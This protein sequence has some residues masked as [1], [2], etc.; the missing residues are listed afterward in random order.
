[1]ERDKYRNKKVVLKTIAQLIKSKPLYVVSA[2]RHS[3]V[4]IENPNN[5]IELAEKVAHSLV[6]NLQFHKNIGLVIASQEV[7]KLN[8][9]TDN[10]FSNL[11]G[12]G[13][14]DY[15]AE[16]IR[17]GMAIGRGASSGKEPITVIIGAIVGGIDAVFGFARAKKTALSE[18]EQYRQELIGELFEEQKTNWTPIYI[19]GGVLLVGGIVTFFALKK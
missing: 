9:L 12:K 18:E 6:N 1:M 17:G 13:E 3:N 10:D 5:K 19:V 15:K 7:G 4:F 11:G 2:L 8:L 14:I 16:S